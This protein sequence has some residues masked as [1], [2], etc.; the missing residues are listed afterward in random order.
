MK[1][2]GLG[3]VRLW[4]AEK[5]EAV[6]MEGEGNVM[7]SLTCSIAYLQESANLDI[8]NQANEN[9]STEYRMYK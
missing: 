2:G 4:K 3:E 5:I 9:T 8:F 1:A 6:E 7:P